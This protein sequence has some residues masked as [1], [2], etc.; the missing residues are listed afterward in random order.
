MGGHEIPLAD[1]VF[2]VDTKKLIDDILRL[3]EFISETQD[4]VDSGGL[5]QDCFPDSLPHF[6]NK[7]VDGG[8]QTWMSAILVVGISQGL[9]IHVHSVHCHVVG[10]LNRDLSFDIGDHVT[11][12]ILFE[13]GVVGFTFPLLLGS[14]KS[15]G[16]WACVKPHHGLPV[17]FGGLEN[18]FRDRLDSFDDCVAVVAK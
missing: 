6:G 7:N 12:P 4:S 10:E 15:S 14:V 2:Y 17:G 16:G 18:S 1:D 8:S 5:L 13:D 9:F 11:C 3:D